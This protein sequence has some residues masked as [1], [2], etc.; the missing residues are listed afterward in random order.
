MYPGR[1]ARLR[2]TVL[3]PS[4]VAVTMTSVQT[5][6]GDAASGCKGSNLV[7]RRFH[8]SRIIPAHGSGRVRLRV[9]MR[10][11]APDACQGVTFPL[12]FT[13]QGVAR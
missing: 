11:R 10:R 4:P 12:L 6:I 13:G 2:V 1:H 9:R 7:V 5:A 8:G 3:N